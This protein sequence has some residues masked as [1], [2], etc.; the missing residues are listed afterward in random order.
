MTDQSIHLL[1]MMTEAIHTPFLSDRFLAI[2][3][4]KMVQLAMKSM[5]DEIEFKPD[6][7]I[8]NRA[9]QIVRQANTLLHEI[10]EMSLFTALGKGVFADIK[11][12]FTGGKGLSGVLTK[13]PDYLNPAMDFLQEV[14]HE[15]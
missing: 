7:L 9:H 8:V 2:Q 6:G 14:P 5:S 12:S 3:N 4:A 15:N 11:R 13:H 1:G 10:A